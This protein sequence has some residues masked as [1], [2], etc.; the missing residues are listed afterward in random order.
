MSVKVKKIVDSWIRMKIPLQHVVKSPLED[1]QESRSVLFSYFIYD[2]NKAV[3]SACEIGN[4]CVVV[5]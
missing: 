4:L 1:I 3:I 2:S 5:W